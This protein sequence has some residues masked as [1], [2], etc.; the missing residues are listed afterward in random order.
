MD[1]E[2]RMLAWAVVLGIA[3]LLT[4]ASAGT[5]QRGLKWNVS[6]RDGEPQPL[7]GVAARLHR[8]WGNFLETFPFFAAL[9][10][11]V[12]VTQRQSEHTALAVQLYF[13]ARLIYVPLYAAGIPY[14]RSLVWAVSLA[15]QVM[16]LWVLLS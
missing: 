11:A 16:L 2:I 9:V 5:A 4:A 15:A 12:V 7:T 6:A 13:W 8:A 10:L 1:I 3:Q 14:L